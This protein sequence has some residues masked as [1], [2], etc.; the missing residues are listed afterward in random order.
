MKT[1]NHILAMVTIKTHVALTEEV[2][3]SMELLI[4]RYKDSIEKR[5]S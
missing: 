4:Q 3:E 2:K 5:T 1:Q